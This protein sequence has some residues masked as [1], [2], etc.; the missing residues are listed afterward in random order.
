MHIEVLV[1]DASG[2]KL[3]EVLLPKL[4]GEQGL[5]HS[6]R[7]HGYKGVGRL[8]RDLRTQADPAKRILLD[9]LPR[10]LRG[11]GQTPAIDAVLVVLDNDWR[12]CTEFLA[13]LK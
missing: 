9:Q 7:I 12:D 1:E 6:W 10:L 8:P 2:A 13:E 11:Y 3:L 4:I 5:P